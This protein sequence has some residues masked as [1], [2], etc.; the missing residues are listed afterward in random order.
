[1]N[2]TKLRDVY[3]EYARPSKVLSRSE[4]RTMT[5][6]SV[7]GWDFPMHKAQRLVTS[8]ENRPVLVCYG[9]DGT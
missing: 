7:L 8:A 1:M 4:R 6:L 3:I 5:Q 2:G 9:A